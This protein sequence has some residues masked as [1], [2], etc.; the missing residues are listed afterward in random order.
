M[1]MA[2]DGG[3]GV[4]YVTFWNSAD[5][6]PNGYIPFNNIG[7]MRMPN[8]QTGPAAIGA[9]AEGTIWL[10]Y[11]SSTGIIR[12]NPNADN[13]TDSY[14]GS[15]RVY[16]YSD[17]TGVVRQLAI[18]R[19]T[20]AED[21]D[22]GCQNPTWTSLDWEGEA[23]VGSTITFVASSAAA[24]GDLSD[25]PQVGMGQQPGDMGPHH[26][27]NRLAAGG[28]ASR[29][30]LRVKVTLQLNEDAESPLL[31]QFQIRWQCP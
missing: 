14:G 28:Q 19:G 26:V 24:A 12:I 7:R 31:R 10:T 5:W 2:L 17:F 15:G 6:R 30:Y 1:W 9:D 16:S 18:G 21:F 25:A 23:P 11:Y 29:Q 3:A 20:Y 13:Q 22:A 4:S 27:S 8:N